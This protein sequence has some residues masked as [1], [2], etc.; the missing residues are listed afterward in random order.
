VSAAPNPI[1]VIDAPREDR[2]AAPAA[3]DAP[4]P[5]ATLA[6]GTPPT[7][8]GAGPATVDA[9]R[10][11]AT[12]AGGAAPT[13][14]AIVAPPAQPASGPVTLR[15]LKHEL[16]EFP[17]RAVREKVREGHVVA[18]IWITAEGGVDQVDI[19]SAVPPRVFDDEVRRAL[20][21]WTFEAPGR[22]VNQTVELTFKP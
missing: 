14:L 22:Q 3:A 20:S 1:A 13:Q 16:P 12:P 8:R 18:R 9:P 2:G 21:V 6:V 17:G 7:Q 11:S 4:R 19:V 5:G 15:P 10:P